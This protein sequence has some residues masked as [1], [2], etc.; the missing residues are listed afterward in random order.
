MDMKKLSM[1]V[2]L[3]SFIPATDE[4]KEYIVTMRPSSTFFQVKV[5]PS[6]MMR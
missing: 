3:D 1:Q 6:S 2:D 5:F 4:E